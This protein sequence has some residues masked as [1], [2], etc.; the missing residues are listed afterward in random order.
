[1][2]PERTCHQDKASL[3]K[4]IS[5][6]EHGGWKADPAKV[7]PAKRDRAIEA[8]I[9]G[10]LDESFPA[11]ENVAEALAEF[12]DSRAIQPLVDTLRSCIEGVEKVGRL[13]YAAVKALDK[14]G[15]EPYPDSADPVY[16]VLSCDW[17]ACEKIGAAA[18]PLLIR[19][20]RGEFHFRE[21]Y[22]I[23]FVVLTLGRIGD[24]RAVEPLIESLTELNWRW[25][26]ERIRAR[27]D[28]LKEIIGYA[29]AIE[30]IIPRTSD[31]QSEKVFDVALAQLGWQPATDGLSAQYWINKENWDECV[32]IG[33]AAVPPLIAALAVDSQKAGATRTLLR[34]GDLHGLQALGRHSRNSGIADADYEALQEFAR[35]R[36]G[37]VVEFLQQVIIESRPL[38]DR[39]RAANWL[40]E[41]G[42]RPSRKVVL[43]LLLDCLPTYSTIDLNAMI[44]YTG[45][46]EKVVE[47]GRLALGRNFKIID[48]RLE[49]PDKKQHETDGPHDMTPMTSLILHQ[50]IYSSCILYRISKKPGLTV[51]VGICGWAAEHR[52]DFPAEREAAYREL[53]RQGINADPIVQVAE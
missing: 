21:D 48:L 1:M 27:T 36:P 10:L 30:M 14:I 6:F 11:R 44:V 9:N 13:Y 45:M 51:K 53:V 29:H 33:E 3:V 31:N 24:V 52:V 17:K 46:D 15:W 39:Y 12:R 2:L 50:D 42:A 25:D 5:E 32:K 19:A 47:F 41:L 35:D 22:G 34:L 40:L 26:T 28:A 49:M 7:D 23:G 43:G 20:L 8:L 18:V 37:E 16:C 38:K 4:L